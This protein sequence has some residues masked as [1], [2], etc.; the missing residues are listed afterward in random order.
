MTE[1]ICPLC[2]HVNRIENIFCTKC[3]TKLEKPVFNSPRL[4]VCTREDSSVV[5]PVKP[6]RTTIGRDLSNTI[7]ISDERISKFHAAILYENNLAWIEDLKSR[8][9][10]YLNGKKLAEKTILN[11]GSLIRLGT[12]ILRYESA[13]KFAL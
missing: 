11:D 12:T 3:G 8:N 5:F 7:V 6:G 1:N 10:I 2:R 13:P 9:G 4:S